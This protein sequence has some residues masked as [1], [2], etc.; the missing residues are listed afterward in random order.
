MSTTVEPIVAKEAAIDGAVAERVEQLLADHP[1]KSPPPREFLGHQFDRGLAWVQ[2]PE[3]Y[4]GMGASPKLQ[5]LI[6]ERLRAAGGA[7]SPARQPHRVGGGAAP[8]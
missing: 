2:F 3:G 5:K 1:P 4:G 8:R 6:D 7:V